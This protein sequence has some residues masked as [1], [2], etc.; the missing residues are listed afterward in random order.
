MNAELL[1]AVYC[2]FIPLWFY[3]LYILAA[4]CYDMLKRPEKRVN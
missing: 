4:A 2:L 3:A 1:F